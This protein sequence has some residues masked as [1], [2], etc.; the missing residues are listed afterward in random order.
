MDFVERLFRCF[1]YKVLFFGL[2][3]F[4]VKN[5][6]IKIISLEIEAFRGISSFCKIDF[7]QPKDNEKTYGTLL[8]G[9]NGSGKSSVIDALE[10]VTQGTIQSKADPI[11]KFTDK[12]PKIKILLSDNTEYIRSIEQHYNIES[13]KR[14]PFI[15]RRDNILQFWNT[16]DD[17]KQVLF[18][19]NYLLSEKEEDHEKIFSENIKKFENM[20]SE[21][22]Q[23]KK[24]AISTIIKERK[25]DEDNVPWDKNYEFENWLKNN[26]FYGKAYSTVKGF[27]QPRYDEKGNPYKLHYYKQDNGKQGKIKLSQYI[28][29]AIDTIINCNIEIESTTKKIKEEKKNKDQKY[30]KEKRMTNIQ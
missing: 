14:V 10:F 27:Y 16:P 4:L 7:Q 12:K 25:I 24:Q 21:Q 20:K 22:I 23:H 18:F 15:L 26:L 6:A 5:M 17:R 11:N 9:D 8:V 30:L 1:R 29:N 19:K 28:E 2:W 13:F 3:H